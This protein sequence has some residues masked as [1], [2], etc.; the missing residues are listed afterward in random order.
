MKQDRLLFLDGLKG[1]A[2][3]WVILHHFYLITFPV[4]PTSWRKLEDIPFVNVFFNGNYAVHLFIIISAFLMTM[5]MRKNDYILSF[6]RIIVKRYFRLMIPIS[7]IIIITCALYY[8]NFMRIH[9]FSEITNN[10]IIS[11]FYYNLTPKD[12]IFALLFS[13]LGHSAVLAPCWMLKY[14]F[15]GTFLIVIICIAIQNV[16]LKKRVMVY[17]LISLLSFYISWNYVSIVVGMMLYELVSWKE[18]QKYMKKW[19]ISI[20]L[21]SS[22]T[23]PVL[24]PSLFHN[25]E[26]INILSASSLFVAVYFSNHLKRILSTRIFQFLGKV[27][28]GVYLVHWPIFCSFSCTILL[29]EEMTPINIVSVLLLSTAL[30]IVLSF[31][32]SHYIESKSIKLVNFITQYLLK[33]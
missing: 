8:F 25:I 19:V 2:A 16:V 31:M 3:I 12:F 1:I 15:I 23:F 11:H 32:Y 6:Q 28:L 26:W 14:I 21:I 22:F 5:I 13:P 18:G 33:D 29:R 4:L 24:S 9:E 10:S 7:V 30:V 20:M 27:S 17:L